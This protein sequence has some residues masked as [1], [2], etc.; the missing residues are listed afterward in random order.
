MWA[1]GLSLAAQKTRELPIAP[2]GLNSFSTSPSFAGIGTSAVN[3]KW[4]FQMCGTHSGALV[5]FP[6]AFPKEVWH[7]DS[8]GKPTERLYE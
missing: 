8:C 4:K 5:H 7:D 6:V 3:P 1:S 2:W